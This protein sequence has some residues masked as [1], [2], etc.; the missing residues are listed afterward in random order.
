LAALAVQALKKFKL[1]PPI[2]RHGR[3]KKVGPST[4]IIL[5]NTLDQY[6]GFCKGKLGLDPS[7]DL[8]MQPQMV[9]KFISFHIAKGNSPSTK[10]RSV[11]Q[12]STVIRFVVS[13]KCPGAKTWDPA[14]VAQCTQWYANLKSDIRI[15]VDATPK[16]KCSVGLADVWTAAESEWGLFL[17]AYQVCGT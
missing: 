15:E 4:V 17:E 14:H 11:Q 8:V 10:L 3:V 1:D 7:L 12:I 16:R 2:S 9:A 6:L 5:E 13:G